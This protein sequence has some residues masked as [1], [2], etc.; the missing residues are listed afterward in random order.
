MF[1]T[2][3]PGNPSEKTYAIKQW[4]KDSR[5]WTEVCKLLL[6]WLKKDLIAF[7]SQW[8]RAG[9][10]TM[11]RSSRSIFTLRVFYF[12]DLRGLASSTWI[13]KERSTMN[14]VCYQE[15]PSESIQYVSTNLEFTFFT[16]FNFRLPPTWQHLRESWKV[17]P[18]DRTNSQQ[19]L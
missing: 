1:D 9:L 17:N 11:H 2:S 10:S 14:K 5:F 7:P 18:I 3:I 13:Y 8:T 16:T 19:Q 4:W 15:K 12:G 6:M